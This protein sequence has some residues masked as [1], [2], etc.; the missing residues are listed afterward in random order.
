[1]DTRQMRYFIA[2]AETLHFGHAAAR[3]NMTQPPFSRQIANLERDLGV[4][5]VERTSRQVTL[6]PAGERFLADARA[7]L[8]RFDDACRDARLVAEGRA[9]ALSLGFMMHAAQTVVPEIVRRYTALQPG[10]RLSLCETTPMEIEQGLINGTLD[11]GITFSGRAMPQIEVWPLFTD[12]L[13]LVTAPGHPLTELDVISPQDLA[14]L[15]VIAVSPQAAPTLRNAIEDFC[16]PAGVE[17]QY[18]FEPLLQHTILRLVAADLGIALVPESI[19]RGVPDIDARPLVSAPEL[20]VVL[21]TRRSR[22]NPAVQPLLDLL[23]SIT[24]F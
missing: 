22:T 8:A 2:L 13:C 1:M 17:P 3:M 21:K 19:C 24:F 15:P 16:T 6:T 10:V 23:G 4:R 20:P 7:V 5:L 11:A 18:R 12:H 9:G 14:G